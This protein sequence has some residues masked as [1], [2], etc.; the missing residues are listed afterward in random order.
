MSKGS[1]GAWGRELWGKR[2]YLTGDRQEVPE[3]IGGRS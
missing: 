2:E 3:G 1:E